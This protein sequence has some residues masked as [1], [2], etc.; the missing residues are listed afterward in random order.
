MIE[1]TCERPPAAARRPAAVFGLACLLT[2]G[3]G[4]AWATSDCCLFGGLEG[5]GCDDFPCEQAVCDTDPFCCAIQWDAD[6]AQLAGVIC[7]VC[8]PGPCSADLNGDTRVD[9]IDLNILLFSFGKGAGGD[10]SRDG[11][12]NSLDLNNL[13]GVFGLEGC[14]GDG[15]CCTPNAGPG[16]N[17][18]SCQN[19]VCELSPLCCE[20]EWSDFC[21]DLAQ[22][23]CNTCGDCC[24]PNGT[25]GCADA[26]CETFICAQDPFCCEVLWDVACVDKAIVQCGICNGCCTSGNGTPNCNDQ[27]CADI[28]CRVDPFCCFLDWDNICAENAVSLCGLCGAAP[29]GACCFIDQTCSNLT[30]EDCL[31]SNGI[32]QGEKEPCGAVQCNIPP[33]DCCV[34]NGTPGCQ[35][36]DC[37]TVVCVIEEACCTVEWDIVCANLAAEFC[38][39]CGGSTAEAASAR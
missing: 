27:A 17:E 9:S 13:L 31:G 33:S 30:E 6:C 7:D 28:V 29:V 23:V 1:K 16:C 35:D 19:E 20:V 14:P 8:N 24:A 26:P 11:L 10:V 21:A 18:L 34:A 4:A 32:F 36:A 22:D 25:E 12:T 5:P 15:T 38:E 2:A 39:V 37:I 3:G